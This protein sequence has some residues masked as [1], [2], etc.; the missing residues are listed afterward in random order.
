MLDGLVEWAPTPQGRARED[1]KFLSSRATSA[2]LASYLK[3]KPTWTRNTVT[4]SPSC[5]LFP[6]GK[7]EQGMKIKY[8]FALAKTSVSADALT[9]VAGD[10][11]HVEEAWPGDIIGLHNHGTI[12]I[13]DTLHL[14][15]LV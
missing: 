4:A 3:S 2:S 5:A 9:F 10:R 12:Q 1:G 7:Y 13:G 14:G 6:G 15:R 8:M 11:E